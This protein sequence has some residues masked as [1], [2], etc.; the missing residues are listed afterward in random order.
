MTLVLFIAGAALAATA[1]DLGP[2]GFCN[3]QDNTT[4]QPTPDK[5][6]VPL[7]DDDFYNWYVAR[8]GLIILMMLFTSCVCYI[9]FVALC[10]GDF[11]RPGR[12]CGIIGFCIVAS[13]L[14]I[15]A[16]W[17]GAGTYFLIVLD[18]DELTRSACRSYAF[19]MGFLYAYICVFIIVCIIGCIWRVHDLATKDEKKSRSKGVKA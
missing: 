18:P 12:I 7:Y 5:P 8:T 11:G 3:E 17:L 2:T 9:A 19:Y 14:I 6:I 13:A 4:V 15:Y 1:G 10:C 16:I